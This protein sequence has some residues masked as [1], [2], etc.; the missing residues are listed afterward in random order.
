[1]TLLS[2]K[3]HFHITRYYDKTRYRPG[4]GEMLCPPTDG[5]SIQKSQR[6]YVRPQMGPQSAYL[7]WPVVVK[8]QAGSEPIA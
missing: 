1:M 3:L 2:L 6:I 8:L 4:G 7:W 5:S